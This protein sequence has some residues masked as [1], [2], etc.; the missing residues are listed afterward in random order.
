[1][2]LAATMSRKSAHTKARWLRIW[3]RKHLRSARRRPNSAANAQE[4]CGVFFPVQ[5]A[6]GRSGSGKSS[7]AKAIARDKLTRKL[8]VGIY[9][10]LRYEDWPHTFQTHDRANYCDWVLRN[11]HL[12]KWLVHRRKRG[13]RGEVRLVFRL[14]LHDG[15]A[16]RLRT[17]DVRVSQAGAIEPARAR[18]D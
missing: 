5:L 2:E 6:I 3:L 9:D 18:A 8:A 16:S 11:H 1:M 12:K 7:L 13:G 17:H 4:W 10:P 14:D 15:P